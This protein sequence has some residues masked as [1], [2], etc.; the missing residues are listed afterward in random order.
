[1]LAN[2]VILTIAAIE[3]C[4]GYMRN[5]IMQ[6]YVIFAKQ[7][8]QMEMWIPKNWGLILCVTGILGGVFAGTISDK[9]FQSR[10]GPV[11]A[12]LYGIMLVGAVVA[13]FT[14]T[15][16]Y[17]GIVVVAMCTAVVGVHG[18]LSGTASMDFGGTRNVGVAVGL[19]DGMVYLGTA[20]Q[21]I[22]LGAVLPSGDAAK[23]PANWSNWPIAMVPMAFIGFVFCLRVWNAKPAPRYSTNEATIPTFATDESTAHLTKAGLRSEAGATV[24][25]IAPKI[26][27]AR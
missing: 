18:M 23:N 12:V 14:Y 4:S 13:L 5:A 22:V 21:S 10:R 24:T 8:G 7:T 3:F 11:S 19:I 6:W 25:S 17:L 2:P 26:N 16:P 15:T 27:D 20:L 1:M 9:L